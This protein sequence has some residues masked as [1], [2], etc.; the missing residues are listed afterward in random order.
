MIQESER[1]ADLSNPSTYDCKAGSE[2]HATLSGVDVERLARLADYALSNCPER[3][4]A[5]NK[6]IGTR[7][8]RLL[9]LALCKN[10]QNGTGHYMSAPKNNPV[11]DA[12]IAL[13]HIA[14]Q[15]K[16]KQQDCP[17]DISMQ[18]MYLSDAGDYLRIASFLE[19]N[20]VKKAA[21]YAAN[22]DT[23]AREEIPGD[24]WD[25]LRSQLGDL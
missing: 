22:L 6:L 20:E 16:N 17:N 3:V 5:F 8:G 21:K 9:V 15:T 23:A 14:E 19:R 12:I 18:S 7:K 1:L 25:F 4:A 24:V 11:K 13:K 2:F 10:L